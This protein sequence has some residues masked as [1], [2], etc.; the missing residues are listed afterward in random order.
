MRA[1]ER[2]ERALQLTTDAIECNAANYTVW[3]VDKHAHTHTHTH[4]LNLERKPSDK[5]MLLYHDSDRLSVLAPQ[6]KFRMLSVNVLS[7][8][9]YHKNS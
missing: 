5:M 7:G 2:S 6:M 3:Y 8:H 1:D 4:T 9:M